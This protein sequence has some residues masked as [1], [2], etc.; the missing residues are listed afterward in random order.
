MTETA[1]VWPR[2]RVGHMLRYK[3]AYGY[4]VNRLR[5]RVC[6]YEH[7]AVYPENIQDEDNQ[8]C[9]KCRAMACEPMPDNEQ[10]G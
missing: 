10:R 5:C 2:R 8:E 6:N 7:I 3:P 1:P 9:P 4:V